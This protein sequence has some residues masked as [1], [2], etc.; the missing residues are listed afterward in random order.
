MW[1]MVAGTTSQAVAVTKTTLA[2]SSEL[3]RVVGCGRGFIGGGHV[4]HSQ[5]SWLLENGCQ[6]W[7]LS[8]GRGRVSKSGPDG[9]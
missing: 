2:M 9:Q 7:L 8:W 6:P 4:T 3:R 5:I 1:T